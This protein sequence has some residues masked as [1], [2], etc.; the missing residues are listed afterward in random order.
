MPGVILYWV[1]D[2]ITLS[3]VC[4]SVISQYWPVC[5]PSPRDHPLTIS[6]VPAPAN[7]HSP[8]QLEETKNLDPTHRPHGHRTLNLN[9]HQMDSPWSEC[10]SADIDKYKLALTVGIGSISSQSVTPEQAVENMSW[11]ESHRKL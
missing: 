8:D 11:Q 3:N 2:S 10:G 9:Q 6:S 4:V 7:D 5:P 1:I